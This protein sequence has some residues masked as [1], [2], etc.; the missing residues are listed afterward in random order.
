MNLSLIIY[1]F[2]ILAAMLHG[3][4]IA[5]AAGI[6]IAPSSLDFSVN[7]GSSASRQL[8]VYNTGSGEAIF[9]LASSSTERLSV[10]PEKAAIPG[11]GMASFIVTA[12]G[13]RAGESDEAIFG[14]VED[15]SG[16][17]RI[18]L[19]TAVRVKIRVANAA[20]QPANAFVGVSLSAGIVMAGLS[21]Y[22]L[23]RKRLFAGSARFL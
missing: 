17:V 6:G 21:A 7:E 1:S 13:T 15:G 2:L 20:L 14:E 12:S 16:G 10:K 23:A 4:G 11:G 18:S 8:L 22:R 9:S 3:P 19:G 5:S